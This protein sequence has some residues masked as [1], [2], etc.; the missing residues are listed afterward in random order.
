MTGTMPAGLI[1]ESDTL[2]HNGSG[3]RELT[4]ALASD[5]KYG[6]AHFDAFMQ[7]FCSNTGTDGEPAGVLAYR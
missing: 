5:A 3:V 7:A 6:E 4:K 2:R 1:L